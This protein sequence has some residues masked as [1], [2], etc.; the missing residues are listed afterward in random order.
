M[1]TILV[2][3][4]IEQIL[5]HFFS[6]NLGVYL[7]DYGRNGC[8]IHIPNWNRTAVRTCNSFWRPQDAIKTNYTTSE[9]VDID[10]LLMGMAFQACEREDNIIVEDLRGNKVFVP[11]SQNIYYT[12]K[13]Y[14]DSL[15]Q[16]IFAILNILHIYFFMNFWT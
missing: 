9:F 1:K 7:R 10:R 4:V 2:F 5:I 6:F 14:H 11:D 16:L 3:I 8:G 12:T 13:F 15:L